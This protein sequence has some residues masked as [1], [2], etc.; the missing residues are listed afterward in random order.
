[1]YNTAQINCS[2]R[3]I[4]SGNWSREYQVKVLIGHQVQAIRVF[5]RIW[6][7]KIRVSHLHTGT[8]VR[9]YR[10]KVLIGHR[11]LAIR[12]FQGIWV[13]KINNT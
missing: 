4:K 5:R 13:P 9:E 6:V 8:S 11:V 10:V 12:V 7:P 3:E 1:M 2:C